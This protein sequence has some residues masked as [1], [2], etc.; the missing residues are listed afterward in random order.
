MN[1]TAGNTLPNIG[2][3]INWHVVTLAGGLAVAISVMAGLSLMEKDTT[4]TPA[5]AVREV[6]ELPTDSTAP[7]K[8]ARPQVIIVESQVQAEA[9][10]SET[11]ADRMAAVMQAYEVPQTSFLVVSSPNEERALNELL[12]EQLLL[13][14][15]TVDIVDLRN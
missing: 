7:Q 14:E 12:M 6:S 10:E 15:F 2:K 11:A 8:S 9:L 4:R 3:R 5:A 1:F 13:A